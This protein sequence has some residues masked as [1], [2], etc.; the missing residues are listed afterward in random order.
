M[1]QHAHPDL[2]VKRASLGKRMDV[3]NQS[4][5]LSTRQ[6]EIE[7]QEAGRA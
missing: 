6:G 2:E 3:L 7:D 1:L 5:G 4:Q